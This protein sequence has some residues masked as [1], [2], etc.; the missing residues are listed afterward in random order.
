MS[1]EDAMKPKINPD[2]M[3]L[4]IAALAFVLMNR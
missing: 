2:W 1:V 4:I 3:Y